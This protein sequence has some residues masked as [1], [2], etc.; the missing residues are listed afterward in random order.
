MTTAF[1]IFF[2]LSGFFS[3]ICLEV[4]ILGKGAGALIRGAILGGPLYFTSKILI[5]ARAKLM[6]FSGF[7]FFSGRVRLREVLVLE[8]GVRLFD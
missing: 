7:A 1:C 3:K 2:L 6:L 5:N 4:R 8:E